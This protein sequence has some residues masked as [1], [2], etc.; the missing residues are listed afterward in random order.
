MRIF[1]L[2]LTTILL[3]TAAWSQD[4]NNNKT[5][6]AKHPMALMKTDLGD[7]TIELW[8][9]IAPKTVENFI[10]LATGTKEWK[11][12]KTRQMVKKPF[13]DGLT[14]HRVI[15][16]FMIQGGCPNGDGTGGPGYSFEDEC[17][18]KGAPLTGKISD[19]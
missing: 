3:T 6:A 17:Y 10:G 5:K 8:P 15:N 11:D 9:D 18:E 4:N 14:F 7:M 19:D 2:F 13:Y 16:D 12:P 1:F